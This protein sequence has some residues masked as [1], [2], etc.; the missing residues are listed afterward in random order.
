MVSRFLFQTKST[1]NLLLRPELTLMVMNKKAEKPA[2]KLLLYIFITL[3]S[4]SLRAQQKQF[5]GWMS[6]FNT[7]KLEKK[8]SLHLEAQLRSNDEWVHIQTLLLRAGLNYHPNKQVVLTAGY[9]YINNR[10]VKS[11]TSGYFTE[12]R[13]WQQLILLQPVKKISI[14]H[15]FRFEER[16]IPQTNVVNNELK[17]EKTAVA[18]RFRYFIRTIIPFKSTAS[19]TKGWY[20]S[21]QNEVFVNIT[22]ANAVNNNFFDQNRACAAFGYRFN[23]SIDTEIGY[24][25][26]YVNGRT[27]NTSNNVI[28]WITFL[29]L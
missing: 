3:V 24:L 12:H 10:T 1:D 27:V 14:Q 6:S 28:Q 16:F 13:L 29:R 8:L 18:T 25:N 21:L 20:G 2:Q 22:N 19:F 17:K 15:R 9:A 26:Q 4:F 23:K 5:S 7:I 11:N